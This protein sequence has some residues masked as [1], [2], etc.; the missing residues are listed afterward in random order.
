MI[1]RV[2]YEDSE[3]GPVALVLHEDA[4][5]TGDDPVMVRSVSIRLAAEDRSPARG[6]WLTA[7]ARGVAEGLGAA[8]RI[9][10]KREQPPGTAY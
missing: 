9:E 10:P 6:D 4:T 7:H 3:L 5:W 1:A 2:T 8:I